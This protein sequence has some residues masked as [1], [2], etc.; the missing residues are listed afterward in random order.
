MK[1]RVRLALREKQ[2]RQTA[3]DPAAR[4]RL[5]IQLTLRKCTVGIPV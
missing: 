5:V 4:H 3:L 1:E 2:K